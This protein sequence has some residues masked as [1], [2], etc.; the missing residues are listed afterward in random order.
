MI[1][2]FFKLH[3]YR[4]R[5][6]VITHRNYKKFHEERFLND[7]KETNIVMKE[8]DPKQIY[9]SL[10]KNILTV[11]NKHAPLRKKIVRGIQSPFMTKEFQKRIYTRSRLKNKM[12]KNLNKKNITAYNRQ[13][14]LCVSLRRKNIKSFINN[15]TKMGIITNKN[16]W[17]FIKPFLTNKGFLENKDITLIEGNKIITSER[18]LAKSF[19]EH[20]IN[21]VEKSSGIKPRDISQCEKKS[22]YS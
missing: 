10:T 12:N 20:Y 2:T 13:R 17:T 7:L 14:S 19:N 9:Q 22:K 16:F 1:I 3:F 11:V 8:K 4:L 15:V 6:K 21:I 18:E 5:P